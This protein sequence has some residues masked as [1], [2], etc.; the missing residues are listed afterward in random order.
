MK[1]RVW[2]E[3]ENAMLHRL[4]PDQHTAEIAEQLDRTMSA[5]YGQ[6]KKLGLSKS[7]EF[8]AKFCRMQKGSRISKA[9][10]FHKGHVS[11]NKGVRSPGLSP[12]RMKETQFRKGQRTGR[13]N[14]VY[15]PVGAERITRE[16]YLERKI[17]DDMPFNRRWRAV[18]LINWEQIHGPI[19]QGHVL[20]F[21]NGNPRDI[22]PENLE[23]ITRKELML[24]NTIHHLPSDLKDTIMLAGRVK[25]AIRKRVKNDASQK[26]S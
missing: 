4:Y 19:P 11:H 23:L 20:A 17:N 22:G 5:T 9:T 24:R 2:T 15:K 1:G 25:R 7:P 6:A 18:H 21:R 13:A 14:L 12:G 26:Q 10:E 3:N 16:G 8:T